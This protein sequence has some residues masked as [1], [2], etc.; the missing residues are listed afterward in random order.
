MGLDLRLRISSA[1]KLLTRLRYL[2]ADKLIYY[3]QT[4]SSTLESKDKQMQRL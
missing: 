1:L 4:T 2:Q 3:T